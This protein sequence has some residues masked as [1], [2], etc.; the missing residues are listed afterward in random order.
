MSGKAKTG[1][2]DGISNAEYHGGVGISKSGL[3]LINQSPAHYITSKRNPKPSTPAMILGTALHCLVLE[4]EEFD[5]QYIKSPESAPSRPTKTQLNAK[6]PSAATVAA[7]EFWRQWDEEN[8]EKTV[9][10]GNKEGDDPFWKP[11]DWDTIHRM[12][13]A[14]DSHP[15]ASILLDHS[16]G[17]AEQ[18]V[19]WVDNETKKLCRCRPDF[20]NDAHNL[21]I[22]L[23]STEDASYSEFARSCAKY[24]YHV[25]DPFYRDGLKAV[26]RKVDGFIFV[27]VEKTPPYGV[28]VYQLDPESV[29]VGRAQYQKN[30][31]VYARCHKDNDW[32]IYAEEIRELE[33]PKWGLL[34]KIS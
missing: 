17:K 6:K 22:D 14:I 2:F 34:G 9:L 29:R 27:A 12:R 8:K 26:N 4:P 10:T 5:K 3:D 23:K 32:P 18:S 30:L 16:Q 11:G 1:I 31:E 25:Q 28:A 20:I 7:I 33:L 13:D 21:A 19:Y 24:R 15:F